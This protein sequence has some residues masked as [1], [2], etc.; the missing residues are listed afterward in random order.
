MDRPGSQNASL[1]D[2]RSKNFGLGAAGGQ[3][4]PLE[5]PRKLT[6]K[7]RRPLDSSIQQWR[8][9]DTSECGRTRMLNPAVKAESYIGGTWKPEQDP[10]LVPWAAR[11]QRRSAQEASTYAG[12]LWKLESISGA[13]REP[14]S[15][16]KRPWK[17]KP[18]VGEPQEARIHPWPP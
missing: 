12:D 2:Q 8:N 6:V 11:I 9:Q 3:N 7:H 17:I 18:H 14:E 10:S 15:S 16:P 4:P 5:C 1:A 13:V